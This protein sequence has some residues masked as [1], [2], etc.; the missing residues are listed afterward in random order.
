[1]SQWKHWLFLLSRKNLTYYNERIK[2]D[3]AA[4]E[5]SGT[6]TV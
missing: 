1:M 2:G 4:D 3:I 6:A 5:Q